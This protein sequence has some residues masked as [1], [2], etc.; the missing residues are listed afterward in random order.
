[1]AYTITVANIAC[2][3]LLLSTSLVLV[4]ASSIDKNSTYYVQMLFR[5]VF[6]IYAAVETN[7]FG[8]IVINKN[9]VLC[10][11]VLSICVLYAAVEVNVLGKGARM[12]R[13]RMEGCR[14]LSTPLQGNFWK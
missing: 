10:K 8:K 6:S 7:V 3:L 13:S 12:L 1:M 14:F 5:F 9:I 11:N 4:G 2:L